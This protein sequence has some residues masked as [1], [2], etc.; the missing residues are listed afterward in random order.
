M[1]RRLPLR[2]PPTPGEA[3]DSW[4][5][6]YARRYE[7][8]RWEVQ[9][10]LGLSTTDA[11]WLVRLSAA[12]LESASTASGFDRECL[13][14]MT[15]DCFDGVCI[16][17]RDDTRRLRRSFLWGGYYRSRY[18]PRC[19]A[20]SGG[21][22]Q[23]AWRL[24]WSFLCVKH[25]CLLE[26]VCR[27]CGGEQRTIRHLFSGVQ[28]ASLCT[29][30]RRN[31]ICGADLST[32][33]VHSVA[34]SH[35]SVAAQRTIYDILDRGY[36]AIGVYASSPRTARDALV[37]IS[38][39]G[40]RVLAHSRCSG[41]FD[42]LPQ[43]VLDAY[44]DDGP[45]QA[46]PW[47]QAEY[48]SIREPPQTAALAAVAIGS[49][50]RI[51]E[52]P[53]VSLAASEM[54]WLVPDRGLGR[55][56]AGFVA[57]LGGSPILSRVNIQAY[58]PKLGP[59]RQLRH[60]PTRTT[61]PRQSCIGLDSDILAAKVPTI[62]WPDWSVRLQ[63]RGR[64]KVEI[65]RQVLSCSTLLVSLQVSTE[66]VTQILGTM[67]TGA[68]LSS[69]L[70]LLS[71]EP[72]WSA[73]TTALTRLNDYLTLTPV[74]V[75]YARRR[76]LDYRSL[77]TDGD[78][79]RL[80]DG[81]AMSRGGP[82]APATARSYLIGRVSGLPVEL[83]TPTELSGN[84]SFAQNVRNFPLHLT[85]VLAESLDHKARCFLDDKDI[86][87]PL[88]W[89]PPLRLLDHLELPGDYV[90]T[91]DLDTLHANVRRHP[92]SVTAIAGTINA[93]ASVVRHLLEQHP[94]PPHSPAPRPYGKR[95][96]LQLRSALTPERLRTLHVVEKKSG[97]SIAE[98]FGVSYPVLRRLAASY[99]MSF[100]QPLKQPSPEW[101]YEQYVVKRR[102]LT[103]LAEEL[104][105]CFDSVAAWIKEAGLQHAKPTYQAPTMSA[106]N[107]AAFLAPVLAR[108][109]GPRSLQN[110]VD[111]AAHGNLASAARELGMDRS[112]LHFQV[113]SLGKDLGGP[114]L[115]KAKMPLPMAPTPLGMQVIDAVKIHQQSHHS[116]V[117]SWPAAQSSGGKS[118]AGATPKASARSNNRS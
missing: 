12:E 51:L 73:V 68:T 33:D 40:S 6:A 39:L 91:I 75:D 89:S 15:M 54:S 70:S 63:S 38:V 83:T 95:P 60:Q 4:L 65:R 79:Y 5:E 56:P 37:D 64:R 45:P 19:L 102:L 43:R 48:K 78:W 46:Q 31:A 113:K 34:P 94:L 97:R 7:V 72:H 16:S 36:A 22:W 30:N 107:A 58:M 32:V 77:L 87:E 114:L 108:K 92:S 105:V 101:L 69:T 18:C 76:S 109:A 67:L 112:T 57:G 41:L 116:A 71:A 84:Y 50:L 13:L 115:H 99:D 28:G 85:S 52:R 14:S 26:D 66:R 8:S 59:I 117:S 21:R 24:C 23:L 106:E 118:S 20:D 90:Q 74:P 2:V 55:K 29:A 98:E 47:P 17:V 1:T 111:A 103:E 110:F 104:G 27:V 3:I 11:K 42:A 96:S 62:F 80:C 81:L 100:V 10:A 9:R 88:T 44:L 82:Q 61:R 49:A 25:L 86:H 53:T 93:D 35:R